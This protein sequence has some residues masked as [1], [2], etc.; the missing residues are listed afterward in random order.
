MAEQKD[1]SSL[2]IRCGPRR[3]KIEIPL[4]YHTISKL[5]RV[6]MTWPSPQKD[7]RSYEIVLEHILPETFKPLVWYFTYCQGTNLDLHIEPPISGQI[8][9]DI[10]DANVRAWLDRVCSDRSQLLRLLNVVDYLDI[11]C[12]MDI[13]LC[14]LAYL[15]HD[16]QM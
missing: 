9:L 16:S 3:K 6:A 15:L 10:P 7:V 4:K 14:K 8:H 11:P 13:L 2:I 1:P 5:F 12:L